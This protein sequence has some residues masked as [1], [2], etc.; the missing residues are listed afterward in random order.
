MTLTIGTSD[1]LLNHT[2]RG[3]SFTSPGD[4]WLALTDAAGNE[5]TFAGYARVRLDDKLGVPE[6]GV[7]INNVTVEFPVAEEDWTVQGIAVYGSQSESDRL[8]SAPLRRAIGVV[9]NASLRFLPSTLRIF[10]GSVPDG[11]WASGLNTGPAGRDKPSIE[12]QNWYPVVAAINYDPIEIG[13]DATP[14]FD[15]QSW[16]PV[17]ANT[18]YDPI[19]IGFDGTLDLQDVFDF[20]ESE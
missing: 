4:V 6:N 8:Q 15:G 14:S 17:V 11:V 12:G 10:I 1:S 2:F 5:V 18:N 13:F 16:Y 9:T 19:E 20:Y 7:V 3:I